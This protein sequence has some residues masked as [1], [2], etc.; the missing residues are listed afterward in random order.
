[1]ELK[2]IGNSRVPKRSSA[3]SGAVAAVA[4]GEGLLVMAFTLPLSAACGLGLGL[5]VRG[6][7]LRL[8]LGLGGAG[9]AAST[10][11]LNQAC[12]ALPVDEYEL[13][14]LQRHGPDAP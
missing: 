13:S 8:G 2:R 10:H 9:A 1:M 3:V 11:F 5:G 7:G 14:R 6:R 4:A 12:H